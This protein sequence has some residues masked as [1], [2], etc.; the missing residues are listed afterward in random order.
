M[1]GVLTLR[2]KELRFVSYKFP[3]GR[4]PGRPCTRWSDSIKAIAGTDWCETARDEL[5]WAALE[6]SYVG[7]AHG[8][9]FGNCEANS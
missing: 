9:S 5:L 6:E 8:E 4:R 7:S 1:Y 2:L 3:M